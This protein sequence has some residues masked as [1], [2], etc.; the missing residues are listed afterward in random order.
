MV[1]RVVQ[2]TAASAAVILPEI[3]LDPLEA[4]QQ[5]QWS[6]NKSG[7][8]TSTFVVEYTLDKILDADVSALWITE[9]SATDTTAATMSH[10]ASGI[11]LNISAASGNNQVGFRVLQTG[12]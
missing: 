9:M 7:N 1:V 3:V 10:P 5:V 12:T 2:S 4:D 6:I 8:G 11:R